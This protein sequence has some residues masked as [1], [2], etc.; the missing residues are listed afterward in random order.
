MTKIKLLIGGSLVVALVA[1]GVGQS[2]L[3]EPAVAA[4][5]GVS[6]PH[7]LVDPLWPKPLPNH[8][9]MGRSIGVDVDDR[10]HIFVVHRDQESM[11][12]NN[13]E[14]GLYAGVSE[15]C[16]PAPPILEFDL[17]GNLVYQISISNNVMDVYGMM[18]DN[19]GRIWYA[20]RF[21]GYIIVDLKEK[22]SRQFSPTN[23]L[24]GTFN[25]NPFQD[26]EGLI[27]LSTNSGANILD[28]KA[29]KNITL[30]IENG[31]LDNFVSSFYQDHDGRIWITGDG[32]IQIINKNKTSISYF[33]E[34]EGLEGLTGGSE[35]FQ[36]KTGKYYFG[37]VNG[38]LFSYDESKE[39]L[40]RYKLNN[41]NRQFVFNLLEDNQ[42]QIWAS[43]AQGG[44]FKIDRK[45]G[46]PGNFTQANGLTDNRVWRTLVA[47]DGKVWIG[48]EGG[49][50][51]YN[52][53]KETIKHLGSEEGLVRDF[54]YALMED[55]KGRI[56]ASGNNVGVSI[57]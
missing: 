13:T 31:L 44:L 41:N 40:E 25:I 10:D 38:L 36:D 35:V 49:I 3:Q 50:D 33:T 17:E 55:N 5:N 26:S 45:T 15:C 22:W 29:G 19:E 7:F 30:T 11:F 57:I 21:F 1:L 18:E 48:T 4:S 39:I 16:T 9:V 12:S 24:L 6:A 52:P 53:E 32:G 14:I 28:L 23:G 2:K 43:I 8:W 42:G 20:N 54:T 47:S 37:S 46:K 56:W 27:W 51:V 34:E